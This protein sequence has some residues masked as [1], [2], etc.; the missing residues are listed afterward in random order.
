ME[1]PEIR[2]SI[3][4]TPKTERPLN[5]KLVQNRRKFIGTMA[6]AGLGMSIV[7]ANVLG[8]VNRVAPSDKITLAYIGVGTQGLRE[9]IEL[10]EL[11]EIQVVAVCD[12]Q[13]KA[14][15]YHDWD[16]Y[17]LRDKVR[18]VLNNPGWNPIEGTIPGGRMIGKMV[19]DS[20]Y[21]GKN[22][23]SNNCRAYADFRELFEK[24]KDLNAVKVMTPDHLHGLIAMAAIKRG[25][26]I[27]MHKPLSTKLLEGREV[28]DM[29]NKSKVITHL[30][31][32]DTNGSMDQVMMWIKEGKI[33]TLKEVHNWTHRPVWP[34]YDF[35][36]TDTP[37]VP[38]GFNWDLWVGPEAFRTYHPHYTNMT[39]RSWYDF[40]G[41][42]FSDMGHYSLWVVFKALELE[43]PTLIDPSFTHICE[44]Q[45]DDVASLVK[46]DYSFPTAS[47]VRF[48]Y[49]AKGSRPAVDLIWYDGGMR[50]EVPE[51]F[52]QTN[53]P[54]PKEGM[55]FVGDKGK[56]ISS[57]LL[58]NPQ[59]ITSDFKFLGDKKDGD[60]AAGNQKKS[61]IQI[62]AN[63]CKS[64]EQT[65]GSFREA[66]HL[67]DAAN[68]YSVALKSGK[69]LK[70]D[71]KTA[72]I[73]NYTELNHMLARQYREGWSP[74]TI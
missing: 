37:P 8:G 20:Y 4:E 26:N 34:Q 2:N 51:E 18:K 7:P 65:K 10:L 11:S 33:G 32:W 14:Y 52:Y 71:S 1:K 63:A 55:M 28:V 66:G 16:L 43:N 31:P 58:G 70:F 21:S 53:Q 25:I 19:V 38:N 13:E 24:E 3:S 72:K 57:F 29:A 40:G 61:G 54:F 50:P 41:G 59:I 56:I 68:L 74:K 39:F 64:G 27:V 30:I 36:P 60:P 35:K 67:C 44:I 15:N 5:C 48:K 49:P 22:G 73:T 47:S 69:T 6:G 45:K 62:F 17:S 9:L 23:K 42:S 12:P 46:N